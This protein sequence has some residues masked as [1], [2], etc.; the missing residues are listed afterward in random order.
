MVGVSM[1]RA[2]RAELVQFHPAA[3]LHINFFGKRTN[4]PRP[5]P[6]SAKSS[7]MPNVAGLRAAISWL[8]LGAG[9]RSNPVLQLGSA[10]TGSEQFRRRMGPVSVVLLFES[11][12]Q[13]Q[14]GEVEKPTG[15]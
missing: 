8:C 4:R 15:Q 3:H 1:L 9:Q 5:N 14:G 12:Q 11:E 2:A 6:N 7:G 10:P 13:G